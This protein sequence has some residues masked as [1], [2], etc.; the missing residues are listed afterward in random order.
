MKKS[1]FFLIF[2]NLLLFLL[3]TGIFGEQGLLHNRSL[4]RRLAAIQYEQELLSLEVQSLQ[5]KKE[6]ASSLDELR[7]AALRLGYNQDGNEVYYFATDMQSLPNEQP[8]AQQQEQ[9]PVYAGIPTAVLLLISSGCSLVIVG[10][11]LIIL[12]LRR[13]RLSDIPD[14]RGGDYEF[15]NDHH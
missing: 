8:V 4:Q 10:L 1:L 14:S 12:K 6:D 15:T 9:T 2:I 3:F 11:W 5:R 13:R 7:D